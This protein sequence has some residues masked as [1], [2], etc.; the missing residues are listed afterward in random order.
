[1][2]VSEPA[3]TPIVPLT[4][5]DASDALPLSIAAGW[6]QVAADWRLL[7]GAGRGFGIR[8]NGA[9]VASGL[10]LPLGQSVWWISM[11]LVAERCRRHGHGTRLLARCMAEIAA[12]GAAMGLDATEFGRP[13]YLPLGFRDA[14]PITRW[15]SARRPA[16]APPPGVELT[17]AGVEDLPGIGAYDAPRSGLQ[18]AAV[19]AA[20]RARA[21]A[22]AHLAR[23][24]DGRLA[25]YVLGRDGQRAVHI[26][27]VVADEPAIGMALIAQAAG[28]AGGQVILD[29]PDHHGS[30]G[31]WL[32]GEGAAASRRFM[33]MLR[34]AAPVVQSGS[35]VLA[36]TGPEFA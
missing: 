6:N 7:L 19:L 15:S 14:Y 27:P 28:G 35:H 36:I 11:L 9:F 30:V 1:M 3:A 12:A 4:V 31:A 21:P 34:G 16:L 10:A 29:V 18:R 23:H 17:P 13:I 5:A 32:A 26:G 8:Q 24:S 2:G 20:L 25:G 33:R 22:L